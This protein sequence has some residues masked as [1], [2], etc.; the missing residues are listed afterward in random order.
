M[1]KRAIYLRPELLT[2]FL[3]STLTTHTSETDQRHQEAW[4]EAQSAWGYAQQAWDYITKRTVSKKAQKTWNDAIK[5]WDEAQNLW[6]GSSPNPTPNPKP[7]PNP[8]PNPNP[9][10]PTPIQPGVYPFTNQKPTLPAWT[11]TYNP[12]LSQNTIQG[13][14]RT[15]TA[16]WGTH[17][18]N[19]PKP[20]NRWF[21]TSTF[22]ANGNQYPISAFPF[23]LNTTNYSLQI[24][25]PPAPTINPNPQDPPS[26]PHQVP[27][28]TLGFTNNLEFFAAELEAQKIQASQYGRIVSTVLNQPLSVTYGWGT[29]AQGFMA[30]IVRGMPYV[31]FIIN[32]ITPCFA[33]SNAII[34]INGTSPKVPA[35]AGSA[36]STPITSDHFIIKMNNGQTWHICTTTT[37]TFNCIVN[38]PSAGAAIT[39]SLEAQNVFNGV[40]RATEQQIFPNDTQGDLINQYKN[41]YPLAGTVNFEVSENI[42][43]VSFNWK[44]SGVGELLMMS[45]P[46]HQRNLTNPKITGAAF[47]SIR[48]KMLGITGKSWTMNIPLSD[49]Q[50][51][52]KAPVDANKKAAIIA[53]LTT[54]VVTPTTPADQDFVPGTEDDSYGF[55]KEIAKLA[56]IGLIAQQLDQ[57]AVVTKVLE[58]MQTAFTPWIDS[59]CADPLFYDVNPATQNNGAG[60][61][62]G[63]CT[64][65]GL[66][67]S[68]ADYGMGWYND[69]HFHFGYFIYA[70]AAYIY[71]S[72]DKNSPF[73]TKQLI[74][75]MYD[76]IRDIANP[77]AD[78][79]FPDYRCMD[80]YLG[81]SLAAGLFPFASGKNQESTSEA[82]NAWYGIYLFGLAT[83][84][85]PI[86]DLGRTLLACEI[87]SAQTY[88][89]LVPTTPTYA[90]L[91]NYGIYPQELL[92][93]K[94]QTNP[95]VGVLWEMMADFQT[96]FA[97]GAD[98]HPIEYINLIHFLPFTPITEVLIPELWNRFQ[99]GSAPASDYKNNPNAARTLKNAF[100]PT[101]QT[102]INFR[103]SYPTI[104]ESWKG[105][106]YMSHAISNPIAAWDN[107]KTLNA[108]DNGNSATNALYWAAT[109][110]TT[111]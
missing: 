6:S 73:I 68:N 15:A 61:W 17:Q 23:L 90:Q 67:D 58:N 53:A 103:N 39:Y 49:I 74:P 104:W 56:R 46:H 83:N 106:I 51:H 81:H 99:Y 12:S 98:T 50:W 45:L 33:T 111:T 48:G 107:I 77:V 41:C 92:Y 101:N 21:V 97:D 34:S 100:N 14:Y 2:I 59:T 95:C 60:S 32:N 79:Y 43:T 85:K 62:G 55:G 47:N 72:D 69:H 35:S 42:S 16:R 70:A 54:R 91:P 57:P 1:K 82:V 10:N 24:C 25:C 19:Y 96:F 20:T 109:R 66:L 26:D 40:L 31:T 29:E 38:W 84:S 87:L 110:Q 8:L 27:N 5:A 44:T 3:F 37:I 89:F 102:I 76:L 65:N 71:L 13:P 80:W 88:W 28:Y 11:G 9:I 75:F 22:T 52:S 108:Y 94:N 30:P 4:T 7:K 64:K 86:E 78:N 18:N 63:I 36:T 105:Y 93:A